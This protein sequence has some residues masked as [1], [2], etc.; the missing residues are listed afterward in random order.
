ML[1]SVFA[2]LYANIRHGGHNVP[3]PVLIGLTLMITNKDK[4]GGEGRGPGEAAR[5]Q[6]AVCVEHPRAR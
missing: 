3:T 6:P 2:R 5:P 1:V 4:T